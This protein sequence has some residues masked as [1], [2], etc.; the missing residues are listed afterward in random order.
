MEDHLKSDYSY[1]KTEVQGVKTVTEESTVLSGSQTDQSRR[2]GS[3]K[4][5]DVISKSD[6]DASIF[7][8]G[9]NLQQMMAQIHGTD[10]SH[11]DDEVFIPP[12]PRVGAVDQG[13]N[14][15]RV[16][17]RFRPPPPVGRGK[18]MGVRKKKSKNTGEVL[19]RDPVIST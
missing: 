2:D 16:L 17:K 1:S 11:K 9:M 15:Q 4:A 10:T 18:L 14:N 3:T 6:A 7:A 5:A 13:A 12:K 8:D 19:R